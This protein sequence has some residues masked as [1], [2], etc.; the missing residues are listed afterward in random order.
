VQGHQRQDNESQENSSYKIPAS[1]AREFSAKHSAQYPSIRGT[2]KQRAIDL[3]GRQPALDLTGRQPVVPQRPPNMR[4]LDTPPEMPR[5]PRPQYVQPQTR[6]MRRWFLILGGVFL[7]FAIIACA[8]G[9]FL[10]PALNASAGPSQVS[11]DFF[12][13]LKSQNYSQSYKDLGPAITIPESQQQFTGQAQS[14]D[15]CYGP[16]SSY[17]EV[18]NSAT[19]QNN[20]YSYSY[21][22]K[23][24]HLSK[25]Y[26]IQIQLQQDSN[27]SGWKITSY[28]DS[29]GPPRPAPACS[30]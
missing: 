13:S 17:N 24:T 3:T 2:T 12:G 26:T 23:R 1:N 29:L 18:P 9:Y 6:T 22:V 25:A 30:K 15:K 7:L 16:I 27:D 28:G 4:R 11:V 5:V 19:L 10:F 14:F 20:I 21:S 8:I